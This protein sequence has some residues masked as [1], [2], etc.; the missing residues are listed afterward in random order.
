MPSAICVRNWETEPTADAIK[1]QFRAALE[2][3]DRRKALQRLVADRLAATGER[4]SPDDF[5]RVQLLA[6]H[7]ANPSW[8]LPGAISPTTGPTVPTA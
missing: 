3:E 1:T 6:A 2:S 7:N 4:N 5:R 8:P